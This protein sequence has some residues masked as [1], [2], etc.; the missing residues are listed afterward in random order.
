VT[1]WA[2]VVGVSRSVLSECCRLVHVA[3]QEARDFTRLLRAICHSSE[4][5][6]PET[7]LDLADVRTLRK[8][9]SR[10]GLSGP[11]GRTPTMPQFLEHQHWIPQTNPGMMALRSLLFDDPRYAGWTPSAE[12]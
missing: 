11:V 12:H 7:V 5:W 9:L 1:R 8:L 6:Q 10:A 4:Q 2:R 3:P